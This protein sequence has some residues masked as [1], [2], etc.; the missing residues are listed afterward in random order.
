M[1]EARAAL[2]VLHTRTHRYQGEDP[3][4]PLFFMFHTYL[5]A[6][7]EKWM[8]QH[9]ASAA[10]DPALRS[11]TDDLWRSGQPRDAHPA[12]CVAQSALYAGAIS[13]S[14]TCVPS[15]PAWGYRFEGIPSWGIDDDPSLA[16][17]LPDITSLLAAAASAHGWWWDGNL[18]TTSQWIMTSP[19]YTGLFHYQE[20][21]L[22]LTLTLSLGFGLQHLR[23]RRRVRLLEIGHEELKAVVETSRRQPYEQFTNEVS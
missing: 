13:L 21:L 19:G 5:D 2:A 4:T 1:A 22:G 23:H 8:R 9:G 12:S 17:P 6:L 11:Y 16:A 18:W 14:Q 3:A 7:F 20:F 10:C 15:D